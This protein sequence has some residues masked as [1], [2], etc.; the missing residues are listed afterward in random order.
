MT[1]YDITHTKTFKKNGQMVLTEGPRYEPLKSPA[2]LSEAV[3]LLSKYEK[4][5]HITLS[6]FAEG[7]RYGIRVQRIK[8][9]GEN[10]DATLPSPDTYTDE[11]FIA[12]DRIIRRLYH[13]GAGDLQAAHQRSD[14]VSEI[15]AIEFT[16]PEFLAGLKKAG[17]EIEGLDAL[18][19]SANKF[20]Y[21]GTLVVPQ[22]VKQ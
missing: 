8:G 10:E 18:P 2:N 14:I 19:I 11:N 12:T 3:R 1:R 21:E 22:I 20:K 17:L 13:N 15:D 7:E 5:G 6:T 4:L 9:V 16:N